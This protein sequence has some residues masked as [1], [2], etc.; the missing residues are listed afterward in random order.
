MAGRI[1]QAFVD[2][3]LARVDIVELIDEYVPLKR[4]GQDFQARCPFHEEKT[5]SFTVSARKQFYH[6]F[7]CGAH[8]TA[9]GFLMEYSRLE[10]PEAVRALAERVG[11]PMPAEEGGLH[12]AD[13][14]SARLY[15]LL[16]QA[17]S[18]YE[19]QLHDPTR[20]QR[21]RAYLTARGVDEAANATF[22]IGYAPP[23]WDSLLKTLATSASV[24]ADLVQAGL[25]VSK[26]GGGA[27][28]RFRDRVLFPILDRRGRTVGFGGRVLDD[29]KPKYLN[30]PETPVFHKG[31]ELYGLYQAQ[32]PGRELEALVVVEGYMDVVALV[33]AG[34]PNVV[35]TLGTAATAQQL[36]HLFRAAP[37]V[38]FCFDGDAA[39]RKAAWRALEVALPLMREGREARFVFLP[40]GEDP[41]TL[42]RRVGAEDLRRRLDT[43]MPLSELLF[44]QLTRRVDLNTLD[45]RARL[46]ALARP[47][48]DRLPPG[49]FRQLVEKRLA[50]LVRLDPVEIGGAAAGAGKG[51]RR[52]VSP[53]R[54]SGP[55]GPSLVRRTVALLLHHPDLAS[56]VSEVPSLRELALPGAALLADLLELLKARPTLTSAGIVEHFRES[57]SGRHLERLAR[58]EDPALPGADLSQ[59]LR[60]ALARLARKRDEQ[61]LE[62]LVQR[63]QHTPMSEAERHAYGELCRRLGRGQAGGGGPTGG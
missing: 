8:G 23:G 41:D 58:D 26:P 57:D 59:E 39:G 22:H 52:V 56:G 55:Q 51:D 46:V 31:R 1:P 48:L 25:A 6:C 35:A 50:E 2:D 3:L 14:A 13:A 36:E 63:A 27:Y 4:A 33:Q 11:M 44:E 19:R 20:G 10:F 29:S 9:I 24:Q 53:P 18:F 32:G 38:V 62:Q 30:S 45:G 17:R 12:G 5:P 28:D 54:R 47:F 40:E 49:A 42:V 16:E 37:R 7:G 61:R 21:A 15:R 34:I 43:G 60:D